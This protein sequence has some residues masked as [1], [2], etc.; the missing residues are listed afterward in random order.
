MT[1]R[2]AALVTA[3][4]KARKIAIATLE[5]KRP[6]DKLQESAHRGGGLGLIRDAVEAALSAHAA[7]EE[8]TCAN[9][10]AC[11]PT[12]E[13]PDD[14]PRVQC[15]GSGYCGG[16]LLPPDWSCGDHCWPY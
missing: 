7:G 13:D 14:G 8:E 1:T 2:E 6:N 4:E 5:Q 3:L 15:K 12:I 9:C 16:M 10:R 11:G